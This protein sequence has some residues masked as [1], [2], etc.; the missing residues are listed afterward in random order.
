MVAYLTKERVKKTLH[1]SIPAAL[2]SLLDIVN[3][4]IDLIMVGYLGAYALA[5]IGVSMSF[6]MILWS[7][8]IVFYTGTNILVSRFVGAK[9]FEQANSASFNMTITSLSVSIPLMLFGIFVSESY[10]DFMGVVGETKA[11]GSTYLIVILLTLPVIFIKNIMT[12]TL[13]GYGETKIP[14]YI[15]S[16]GSV[17]NV[18]LNYIFIYGHFGMPELQVAGAAWST[19]FVGI[20]ETAIFFYI[21]HK[22]GIYDK[23]T[24]HID[25]SYVKRGLKVGIPTGVER[26]F[27]FI[28]LMLITKFIAAYSTEALA[29]YQTGLRAEGIAYMPGVGFMVAAMALMGQSIGANEEEEGYKYVKTASLLASIFMGIIGVGMIVFSHSLGA[30]FTADSE[31]IVEIARYLQIIGIS[32]I[33]LAMV[34]VYDGGLRGA[35]ATRITFAVNTISIWGIRVLPAYLFSVN[36][37]SINSI[38]WVIVLETFI[39]AFVLKWI[40]DKGFWRGIKV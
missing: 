13:N 18:I 40:F 22:K 38:Y 23:R 16:V 10:F 37:F 11:A 9:Q 29:G 24:V 12:S 19:F 21:F 28:S 1:I 35:G 3:I 14:F 34:F 17:V 32:Q 20:V 26:F 5:S 30:I 27:T 7:F 39:R 31:A 25:F 4:V 6:M 2:N 33:P 15:K 8:V 36:N